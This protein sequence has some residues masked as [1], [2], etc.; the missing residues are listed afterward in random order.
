MTCPAAEDSPVALHLLASLTRLTALDLIGTGAL[1]GLVQLTGLKSL[2]SLGLNFCADVTDE[3]LQPLSALTSLTFLN[4]GCKGVQ[5]GSSLAALAS[6]RHLDLYGCSS[7][8]AAALA[9]V[10]QLTRLTY[11]NISCSAT[12]A[13]PAQLAQL[14]QLTNLQELRAWDHSI[15]GE[16]AAALLDLPSLGEFFVFEATSCCGPTRATYGSGTTVSKLPTGHTR[17]SAAPPAAFAQRLD[18]PPPP[19]SPKFLGE[20]SAKSVAVQ[21]GQDVSWAAA[22]PLVCACD[23][24]ASSARPWCGGARGMEAAC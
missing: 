17:L 19:S 8:G 22:P 7:L 3:H 18:T 1:A 23:W 13:G 9:H 14:A 15:R 12:G 4:V 11:L 20:L 24:P 16:A 2:C 10:V 5:H 6:L 21:Q